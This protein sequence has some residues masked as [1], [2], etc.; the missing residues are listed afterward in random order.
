MKTMNVPEKA[1]AI[2][3]RVSGN[4]DATEMVRS[5]LEARKMMYE[6]E[7]ETRPEVAIPERYY[8]E[9][10]LGDYQYPSNTGMM[11]GYPIPL[12]YGAPVSVDAPASVS[13][14]DPVK[15]AARRIMAVENSKGN[16]NGGWNAKEGRWYPHG[17]VE[18]G[19]DTIA[20][21]IKLSNGTPEAKLALKQGYLTDE[22]AEHFVDTLAQRYYD[23]AKGVYDKKY[24]AGEWDKLSDK[25]Q[26]ILVDYSYNPGLAKFPKLMEGF[27]SGNMDLIRQNYKRYVNGK[28]L[29]R[30]KVLLEELDTLENEY[31]IFRASGG[32]IRIKPENR[33]KFT[34]LLKRTGKSA[35]WFKAHG[36]PLQRK[37]A[38]FALNARKWRHGDGGQI[39]TFEDGGPETP[40]WQ[41]ALMGAAV[42]EN[43]SVMTA[44]G[45]RVTPQ[46][47]VVQDQVEE[48][49][50]GQLRN[51][52]AVLGA[53][54]MGALLGGSGLMYD[55]GRN[56]ALGLDAMGRYAMPSTFLKGVSYYVPKVA[57][58][59]AAV[60]PW[61]DAGALSYWSSKAGQ[62]A[63]D[64]A[65]QGRKG[66][67]IG[68]GLLASLP[69]TLPL[70]AM[71]Y[72][73]IRNGLRLNP[74]E[75][76]NISSAKLYDPI[77]GHATAPPEA[78][79][80]EEV[81]RENSEIA[82][83][84]R[85]TL[86]A[87]PIDLNFFNNKALRLMAEQGNA[88]AAAELATRPYEVENLGGGYMLKSLMRG[89]PLEKQLSK[90]GTVNVNN[91]KAIVGKGNKV[92]QAIVDKVL[93]SEEFAGKK[94][95][96]YNKFRKAVQDELITYDR[97]PD[98]RWEDYGM[99][100]IGI[101]D[102]NSDTGII[103]FPK[104]FV[105]EVL[106]R[107]K[108][109]K[110]ESI[111]SIH[112]GYYKIID[113][114]GNPLSS[115]KINSLY[116]EINFELFGV[117]RE[118]LPTTS[119]ETYIFSSPRI[120]VG[121]DKHYDVNTLGHSRTYTTA[122][123]PDILHVMESQS[124]W[125][126]SGKAES[127]ATTAIKNAENDLAEMKKKV[128]DAEKAFEREYGIKAPDFNPNYTA[129]PSDWSYNE[130]LDYNQLDNYRYYLK[131]RV[132]EL[133]RVRDI[134]Y[135]GINQQY[136]ADNFTSRQIQENLRYAAEK[137]Q[138][139]MRYP[140][141][142]TAAKIE[143]YPEREAYFDASGRDV[144]K[145]KVY[146]YGEK[147]DARLVEIDKELRRIENER[148]T[149]DWQRKPEFVEEI[150][151]RDDEL[152]PELVGEQL[153]IKS[154]EPH[155][156]PG[157]TKKTTYDY[158]DILRKYT[159][160]P[161]Q[162]KKL[163]KGADVR[164]VADSKGN[165]WYEVDVPDNYLQQE[166]AFEEGGSLILPKMMMN[167]HSP[168]KLR[169]AIASIRARQKK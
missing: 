10:N 61:L 124:D 35:S 164:T 106:K 8:P 160:F 157:I 37:R 111:S 15:D 119:A 89:N 169:S 32:K 2:A 110:M 148:N 92:E 84:G 12:S 70:G 57:G 7:P 152:Y 69:I 103:G 127:R 54:G 20:Y 145:E 3:N 64:S 114:N 93:A 58:T 97:T 75:I 105:K 144:T 150:R 26:S 126:Q 168:D 139:K 134:D 94:A 115:A 95:I 18:G 135:R 68:M 1:R 155:L 13:S 136:L 71:A 161:K 112:P 100:R 40:W 142:E 123:E 76:G 156:K 140:T 104:D 159:E 83:L 101:D 108:T 28:E 9:P 43:P 118:K 45:W 143:G 56:A 67:A 113:A 5:Y 102:L 87:E 146:T 72:R 81:A 53:T 167:K 51:N 77:V 158:E 125:A 128:E 66:D 33:G 29:G 141:R 79:F 39:N 90:N 153:R 138:T 166:W 117:E 132:R 149:G 52:L 74:F 31:P 91:V 42:A 163:F 129:Q 48:P 133:D 55:I 24:G 49:G 4:A 25:S 116:P 73:G 96:D 27:H 36:T 22:Q 14:L 19:A 50:V 165:T 30:N 63:I 80:A 109:L 137:G 88:K 151:K 11:Q 16:P 98:T 62:Q 86:L 6:P 78:Y 147:E 47:D 121:S 60:S 162:Y 154:A 34:A 59:V 122:D 65:K 21:G 107:D 46:G 23:A 38:T 120:P 85:E 17:S 99:K 44:A 130:W 131:N 41:R 82:R